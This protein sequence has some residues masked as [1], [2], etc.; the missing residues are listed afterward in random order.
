[1]KKIRIQ[2]T[3]LLIESIHQIDEYDSMMANHFLLTIK[4]LHHQ[5]L[6]QIVDDDYELIEHSFPFV[7]MV[8]I[9]DVDE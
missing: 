9:M 4:F 1:M 2:S 3:S 5:L 8:E 6:Y 7:Y